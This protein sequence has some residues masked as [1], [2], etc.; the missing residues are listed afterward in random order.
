MNV[1]SHTEEISVLKRPYH[2]FSLIELLVVIGIIVLLIALLLPAVSNMRKAA[3]STQCLANLQTWGQANQMYLSANHGRPARYGFGVFYWD[4]LAP[5]DSN[6]NRT[7]LCPE[8]ATIHGKHPEPEPGHW[9]GV[10]GTAHAAWTVSGLGKDA[11]GSYSFNEHTTMGKV[12][13]RLDHTDVFFFTYPV[14]GSEQVP[15]FFDCTYPLTQLIDD[16][17]VP[18]DL[19]DPGPSN[20][21]TPCCIDRHRMAINV[22]FLDG[23][24]ER[25]PLS[26]LWKLKWRP[27]Y[28]P[29][30]VKV[31]GA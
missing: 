4:V 10:R 26:N 28:K 14:R 23:H 27:D 25:V 18:T 6:V 30:D 24:A 29:R 22:A 5:Y 11:A 8:A 9:T 17:P 16:N 7:L 21:I 13:S 12:Y 15:L 20:G 3:R 2:G 31:P 19:E 1:G